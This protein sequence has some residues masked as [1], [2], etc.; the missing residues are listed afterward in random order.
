MAIRYL[1]LSLIVAFFFGC[2]N[3]GNKTVNEHEHETEEHEHN[4]EDAHDH[5][6]VKLKLTAYSTDI[7]VF[8]ES[9]PFA[10]GT[11]SEILAHFSFL[12]NFKP[13]ENG[14]IT[15]TLN[16]GGKQVSQTVE[17]PLRPGIYLFSLN[18]DASG[19]GNLT[20]T[21]NTDSGQFEV[22]IPEIQ[23]YADEHEAI[24]GTEKNE[25]SAQT[26]TV[27][28]TK[29]QS[30]KIDFAT[31]H[32][33]T[34]TFGEVVKTTAL[35]EPANGD[36]VVI[37]AKTSGIVRLTSNNLVDG[38]E[39]RAGQAL[40]SISGDELSDNNLSVKISEAQNNYERAKAD[41]ERAREL[42]KDKIVSDKELLAVKNSF[43]NTKAV[44]DNL[45][46]NFNANGQ[47]VSSPMSGFI[48]Q[49]LVKNGAYVEAGQP[50]LVVSQNKTLILTAQVP[51]KYAG[52][53]NAVQSATIRTLNDNQSYT[54]EA[55]G[56][57]VLSV[58]KAANSDNFL[59]PVS[60]QINNTG[61]FIPG[62]FVEVYLKTVTNQQAVTVPNTALL[63]EQG[64]FF[65]W[66]QVTPE[67]FEKREVHIGK[68]D[69]IDTEIKSGIGTTERIVARGAMMIKLAQA[70][71][72]LD[73]H[74]GHVH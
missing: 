57:K 20:F 19:I 31:I 34:G 56:G 15:A 8:A 62:S 32:P 74:S 6:E 39:V 55:L 10:S 40:F 69:G 35:I 24:H 2:R 59:I 43:E 53:L 41:Y 9:D 61:N 67:L 17:K 12:K 50:L 66:V 23:I 48:K 44:Y 27:P 49:V 26:N 37:S 13:V 11:S 68:T 72:S 29:E 14:S 16:L 64:V 52:I 51:Q 47:S 30:W 25:I 65:V 18:P 58:G 54:L 45:N 63:E 7:E 3:S 73:A 21:L 33:Q 71:G 46:R 36:E 70:T 5:G 38:Q 42:S 28:F 1:F 60:M 22:T 4:A